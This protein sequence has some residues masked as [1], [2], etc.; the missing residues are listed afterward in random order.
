M[1]R[2]IDALRR[3][4]APAEIEVTPAVEEPVS[5]S[6]QQDL[7][8]MIDYSAVRS[9]ASE[10]AIMTLKGTLKRGETIQLPWGAELTAENLP[11]EDK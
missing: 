11:L 2:F 9:S 8:P 5:P 10:I 6:D 1:S 4:P 3:R 7:P